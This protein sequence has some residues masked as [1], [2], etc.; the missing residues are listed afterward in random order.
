MGYDEIPYIVARE[1]TRHQILTHRKPI[2]AHN[3]AT[4]IHPRRSM[5]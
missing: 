2:Q 1:H 3:F 4:A 5:I